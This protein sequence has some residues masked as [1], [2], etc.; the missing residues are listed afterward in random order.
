MIAKREVRNY[1]AQTRVWVGKYKNSHNLLHWHYDCELI[2]VENGKINVFC[3]KKNHTL[4]KGDSLFID[5]EQVHYMHAL[6]SDTVLLVII[7]DYH[8][9]KPY[10]G[11]MRLALPQLQTRVARIVPET[12]I[13]LRKLLT[14]K[15]KLSGSVA[16]Y[17]VLGLMLNIFQS[18]ELVSRED[19]ESAKSFK[20]L[21]EEI[22]LKYDTFSFLEGVKFMGMS[23]GYFSRYFHASAGVTFSQYLNRV[24]V[25]NA[26]RMIMENKELTMLEISERCGFDTVRNFNRIF[27]QVTGFAP[28]RLPRG[29]VLEEKYT[30]AS[31]EAFNPDLYGCELIESSNENFA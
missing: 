16:A 27:K 1:N 11:E 29:F 5:S 10:L 31:E 24:R 3:D 4:V 19:P 17:E 28:S 20:K 7:F 12:Y 8:I 22:N 23:E 6:T 2:Y 30:T 15:E 26:V 21:L 14:E 13:R 18:E 9:I 25:S